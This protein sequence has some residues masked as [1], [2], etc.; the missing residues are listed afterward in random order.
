MF[1]KVYLTQK[2]SGKGIIAKTMFL[3]LAL[4]SASFLCGFQMEDGAYSVSLDISGGSG[5]ASVTSPT[6][7]TVEHGT[8]VARIQ[9]S[10]ANY[11]Y[12][13]VDGIT[14]YNKSE[15]GMHSVFE[16]PVLFWDQEMDVIADTT[17]MGHPVEVNYKFFFYRDSIGSKNELP[18]EA[19][20]RVLLVAFAIIVIGG[21]LNYILKKKNS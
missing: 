17:A 16:I 6:L 3:L 15:E 12:M 9:W 7:L 4:L 5:K 11:D 20:K 18:Q 19:A 8:P 21:L 2:N 13:V 1:K 10:S 14:Y